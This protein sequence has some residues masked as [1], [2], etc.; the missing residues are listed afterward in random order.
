MICET[1]QKKGREDN[2]NIG[3]PRKVMISGILWLQVDPMVILVFGSLM[4][5]F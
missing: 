1:S 5:P 3:I 2:V 4:S